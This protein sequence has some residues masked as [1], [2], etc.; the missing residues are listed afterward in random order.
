MPIQVPA[1]KARADW[2]VTSGS[3]INV[4]KYLAANNKK[5]IWAP[6]KYLGDYVQKKS[7]AEM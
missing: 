1:V 7:G 6:D 2:M 5:I 3:A 4:I